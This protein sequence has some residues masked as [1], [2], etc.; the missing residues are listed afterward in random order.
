MSVP[1]THESVLVAILQH[2]AGRDPKR[3]RLKLKL[4]AGNAFA[5]FRGACGLFA[6]E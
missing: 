1:A 6:G 4:M 3:V 5:F 2:D